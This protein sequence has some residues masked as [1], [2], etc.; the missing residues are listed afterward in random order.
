MQK[1]DQ[2]EEDYTQWVQDN[3]TGF[4][5]NAP[6]SGRTPLVLHQADCHHIKPATGWNY[7]SNTQIKVCASDRRE[8]EAWAREQGGIIRDCPDCLPSR[9]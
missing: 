3:P 2:H 8:V 6:R 4:V 5:L 7:A 1:F 9:R